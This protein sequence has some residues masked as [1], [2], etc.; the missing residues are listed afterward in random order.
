[1]Y[2]KHNPAGDESGS[3]SNLVPLS[4]NSNVESASRVWRAPRHMVPLIK[5]S[6]PGNQLE[7]PRSF[8]QAADD[9]DDDDSVGAVGAVVGALVE[10]GL[11][12]LRR[13]ETATRAL[14]QGNLF[15]AIHETLNSIY[16][17][18]PTVGVG[19]L[20]D[21]DAPILR[22]A[23]LLLKDIIN[24]QP[25]LQKRLQ[26]AAQP[27]LLAFGEELAVPRSDASA[28]RKR[29]RVMREKVEAQDGEGPED[30]TAVIGFGPQVGFVNENAAGAHMERGGFR[31]MIDTDGHRKRF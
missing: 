21:D 7:G 3:L 28:L 23:A 10:A 18:I 11:M 4:T 1:M 2:S 12:P 24:S 30:T 22:T 13:A 6:R 8:Q 15:Q 20:G 14:E 9:G 17:G 25:E 29:A 31:D 26:K 16:A 19:E 27:V 5:R